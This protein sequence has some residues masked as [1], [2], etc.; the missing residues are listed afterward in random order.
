MRLNK[1]SATIAMVTLL[2]S[3]GSLADLGKVA[4]TDPKCCERSEC[5]CSLTSIDEDSMEK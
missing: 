4:K 3:G 5:E 2:L 1:W